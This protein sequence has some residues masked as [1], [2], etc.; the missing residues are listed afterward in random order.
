MKFTLEVEVNAPEGDK[1]E[2]E[3]LV[4]DVVGSE[5][6]NRYGDGWATARVVQEASA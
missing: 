4:S 2:I 3:E 5:V 6:Y 1:R